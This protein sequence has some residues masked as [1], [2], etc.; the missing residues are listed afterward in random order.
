MGRRLGGGKPARLH[1]RAAG[2]SGSIVECQV[3]L[4]LVETH[5]LTHAAAHLNGGASREWREKAKRRKA[6]DTVT[7]D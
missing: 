4:F 1:R 5:R 6:K 7:T 2:C 3:N